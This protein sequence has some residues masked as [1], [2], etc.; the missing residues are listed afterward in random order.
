ML[1]DP[2]T[3][4]HDLYVCRERGPNETTLDHVGY[5]L[6]YDKV[7][8]WFK[9]TDR[10]SIRPTLSKVERFQ[11]RC[12]RENKEREQMAKMFFKNGVV[13]KAGTV[14]QILLLLL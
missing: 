8:N 2:N 3:I 7:A 9:T 13:P 10:S 1:E 11:Q 12:E 14:V 5:E 4:F 6:D